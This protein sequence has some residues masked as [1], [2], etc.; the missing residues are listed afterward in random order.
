MCA[1]QRT[2]LNMAA[3]QCIVLQ[4]Y[5]WGCLF[6]HFPWKLVDTDCKEIQGISAML[7]ALGIWFLKPPEKE[8]TL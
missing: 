1:S 8:G 6:G 4:W 5:V 2:K 3:L 7:R